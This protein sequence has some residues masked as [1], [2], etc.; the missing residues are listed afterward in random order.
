MNLSMMTLGDVI[1]TYF[2]QDK[3][4]VFDIM[5]TGKINICT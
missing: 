2:S 4:K 3:D 5:F 1:E